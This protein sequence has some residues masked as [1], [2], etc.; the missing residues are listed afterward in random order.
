MSDVVFNAASEENRRVIL[1]GQ[2]YVEQIHLKPEIHWP[3]IR[4]CNVRI[5]IVADGLDF[6]EADF[7]LS[8]FVRTLLDTPGGYVRFRITLAHIANA[9]ATQMLAGE[10]R[11]ERRITQFKFD[12][13]DHFDAGAYDEVMLFGIASAFPG[14]GTDASGQPYPADRLSTTE[15][16]ALTQFMNAGGGLFATGDHGSLG[17]FLCQ[18]VPRAR[19]M[20][21]WAS[22]SAQNSTDEVSMAGPRRNDTNRIGSS[23]GSS[24][25]DQS[26]ATPQ[27]IQPRIYQR[28][29]GFWRF[30][31]PHPLLCGK[32]GVISVMPD[33]PHEG[34]CVEPTDTSLNL[35]FGGPLGPEYPNASGGG[36]RPL[37]EVI[38]TNTVFAGTT[39]SGKDPTFSQSFG[40]I[41][42][43]DGHRASVGR[44]VTDA[45]WHHF[46]NI[47]L[48]GQINPN[49][50][51]GNPKSQTFA[52]G[53][54]FLATA[55]GQAHLEDIRSY[56]RNL[57][58]WMAPPERIACMNTR[59][60][61]HLVWS[62]RVM[63]AVLSAPDVRLDKTTVA[64]FY[65]IGKHA[66]DALGQFAS[67][68]QSVKLVLDLV[69]ESALPDL[70]PDV[71]PWL[72]DR[73]RRPIGPDPVPWFDGAPLLD[74]A[75][76]AALV[77]LREAFPQPDEESVGR[78]DSDAI[79]EVMAKAGRVGVQQAVRSARAHIEAASTVFEGSQTKD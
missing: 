38:S 64:T 36:A 54:G 25:D 22:T 30:S 70:I 68:C 45:T 2:Q 44:V 49:L 16:S 56:Y 14:R 67:Q 15:L 51:S 23:P 39:S 77:G 29:V 10:P 58:V 74:I 72:D 69:L 62:H 7:G 40:G 50:G 11:I 24:F 8:T 31:F 27:T 28:K 26:D 63:E 60:S 53:G 20:R 46:V 6:S 71:D 32:N 19:N 21:L 75:L 52:G 13:P 55:A 1:A 35:N 34:E 12:D 37:P 3:F 78:L 47:N 17:R 79:A 66:R 73:P 9:S 41:C 4:P 43:Y 57:A 61:W 33:H 5:L 18:A 42:A 65:V 59:L 48:V 76:G